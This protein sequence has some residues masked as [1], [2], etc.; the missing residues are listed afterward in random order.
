MAAPRRQQPPARPLP[1]LSPPRAAIL[2][3][4]LLLL[5]CATP[6]APL[7]PPHSRYCI[8]GAGPGGLQLGH[9]MHRAGRDYRLFERSAGAGSFFEVRS[10]STP[11]VLLPQGSTGVVV[12]WGVCWLGCGGAC[13]C[14]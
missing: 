7:S 3:L 6:T 9:Y 2:P 14:C 12:G 4:G 5:L 13:C 10:H 11:Q 1:P 8:L